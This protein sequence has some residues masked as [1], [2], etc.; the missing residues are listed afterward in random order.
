MY[1]ERA[2]LYYERDNPEKAMEE[3]KKTLSIQPDNEETR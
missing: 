1:L 2:T 3:C